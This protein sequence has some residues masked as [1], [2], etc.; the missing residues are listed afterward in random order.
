LS[1]ELTPSRITKFLDEGLQKRY[2][3]AKDLV[4]K[5][6]GFDFDALA[7]TRE[8]EFFLA[9]ERKA[10]PIRKSSV[11]PEQFA[12]APVGLRE[13]LV[14]Y[15]HQAMPTHYFKSFE[16]LDNFLVTGQY[17]PPVITSP[18]RQG[19]IKALYQT[20][21]GRAPSAAAKTAD[22]I[23]V[24][25]G[26]GYISG[27]VDLEGGERATLERLQQQPRQP[28]YTE[29]T[30]RD[31]AEE[32]PVSQAAKPAPIARAVEPS[33]PPQ[34]VQP[35]GVPPPGGAP[36][37][38][39][40]EAVSPVEAAAQAKPGI[41]RVRLSIRETKQGQGGFLVYGR[42]TR[43]RQVRVLA[44]TLDEAKQAR[45]NIRAGKE[46]FVGTEA[47]AADRALLRA[48]RKLKAAMK[49]GEAGRIQR[50]TEELEA[51]Q[52]RK[53]QVESAPPPSEPP[54]PPSTISPDGVAVPMPEFN[55]ASAKLTRI[56]RNSA[57][58]TSREIAD[59]RTKEMSRRAAI[60][61]EATEKALKEGRSPLAGIRS[62]QKGEL[63]TKALQLAD[64][65]T[66]N[67]FAVLRDRIYKTLGSELNFTSANLEESLHR[68]AFEGVVPTESEM[69]W[70]EEI[71][72]PELV[73]AFRSLRG[74]GAKVKETLLELWNLPRAVLASF[75]DSMV[76]R[77]GLHLLPEGAPA[78]KAFKAHIRAIKKAGADAVNEEIR[79]NEWFNHGR[80]HGLDLTLP[81]LARGIGGREEAFFGASELVKRIPV[82]G[83]G[84][85]ISERIATSYLNKLRMESY[86][87]HA[88]ELKRMNAGYDAFKE[89]AENINILSGRATL[90][91][92]QA[93]APYLNGVF[94]SA[95]LNWAR[96]Q[97]P[98]RIL[99]QVPNL[100]TPE[101]RHMAK[102]LARD[103]YG[104]YAGI[105]GMVGL[106]SASGLA[107]VEWDPKSSDFLKMQVGST[108]IDPW[109]GQQQF[110]VLMARLAMGQRQ[111]TTTRQDIPSDP[112]DTIARFIESKVHPALGMLLTVRRGKN[113]V[114]EKL[115]V[116][117]FAKQWLPLFIQDIQEI[118]DGTTPGMAGAL[119]VPAFFGVSVY[120]IPSVPSSVIRQFQ[121]AIDEYNAIPT[122]TLAIPR[123]GMTRT[124]W[125]KQNAQG[126]A[127]LFLAGQV[128]TLSSTRAVT[129]VESIIKEHGIN[130][131]WIS[132][133][134]ER[135]ERR[136]IAAQSGRTLSSNYVDEL[137]RRLDISIQS[138]TP[139]Q[140][141]SRT[142]ELGTPPPTERPTLK[143]IEDLFKNRSNYG[144][145]AAPETASLRPSEEIAPPAVQKWEEVSADLSASLLRALERVWYDGGKLTEAEEVKLRDVW[146]KHSF[147]QKNFSAWLKQTLRQVQEQ[148]AWHAPVGNTR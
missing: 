83:K 27:K 42:D 129:A 84:I 144:P 100:D 37:G 75:D 67:E 93:L 62:A 65:I 6:L 148:A 72:G 126:E 12:V 43:N 51:A 49:T 38:R 85:E 136:A 116:K 118:A 133:V 120:N 68:L 101:G 137:L 66:P 71:F 138:T 115:T 109:A 95:R 35:V 11:S 142:P 55:E 1:P 135:K 20:A 76:L 21:K 92:A 90:G 14:Q 125:R 2:A 69:L 15:S 31:I 102:M 139:G 79:A 88:A 98:F 124:E 105:L 119:G 28:L 36:A 106:A 57:K 112:V 3:A 45:E 24:T 128:T 123:G 134:V 107:V 56:I 25:G 9:L 131:D 50:V 17:V 59:L 26:K 40:A 13:R 143:P 30:W 86:A 18:I 121:E 48:E 53:T 103:V 81:N 23:T 22:R 74:K 111:T 104:M 46:A 82:L 16:D 96:M 4:E 145:M 146:Q 10:P 34:Q 80:A 113:F 8:D 91:R 77:Q 110:A 52:T 141:T 60:A 78:L 97:T 132:G 122:D 108:R 33:I 29:G 73:E 19:P 39:V 64:R 89:L 140:G 127:G 44:K 99:R 47:E 130:P 63:P 61:A 114:G 147:G 94:F 41:A 87:A 5:K 32:M 117:S 54:K 70:F 58:M 7:G